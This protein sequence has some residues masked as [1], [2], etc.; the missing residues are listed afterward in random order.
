MAAILDLPEVRARVTRWTVA[1]Y[2][3]L[4]ELGAVP[5]RAELLRGLI[6][7]KMPKSPLH[8]FLTDSI[9]DDLRR[10]VK[11]G[12]AVRQELSLRFMDSVP[13]PD[14]SVVRGRKE[15]FRTQRPTTAE[16]VIEVAVSSVALDRENAALYAEAGVTEYWIVLGE[17]EQVETYRRPENGVYREQRTY[18]RGEAIPCPALV[19][20]PIAVAAWFA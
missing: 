12:L 8:N 17:A 18:S 7:E 10:R 13:E 14:V 11:A 16:L 2:E 6:V 9:A 4:A 15:D 5:R 3:R 19:D 1:D 20:E